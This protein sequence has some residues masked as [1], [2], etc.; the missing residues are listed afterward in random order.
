M[1]RTTKNEWQRILCHSWCPQVCE[2]RCCGLKWM[3]RGE[4]G[5]ILFIPPCLIWWRR[6]CGSPTSHAPLAATWFQVAV[7]PREPVDHGQHFGAPR[8]P[9][10]RGSHLSFEKLG[11]VPLTLCHVSN[12][13]EL[14]KSTLHNPQCGSSALRR[15]TPE[16]FPQIFSKTSEVLAK[17]SEI[18]MYIYYSYV[19]H[20]SVRTWCFPEPSPHHEKKILCVVCWPKYP[21]WLHLFFA[22]WML[23]WALMQKWSR[24]GGKWFEGEAWSCITSSLT[25]KCPL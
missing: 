3:T 4:F 2:M 21:G 1:L 12:F 9:P 19:L 24:S 20:K 15:I 25:S 22:L 17:M 10:G 8:C 23:Q 6:W 14:W 18:F 5:I 13:S 16:H 7:P 11:D